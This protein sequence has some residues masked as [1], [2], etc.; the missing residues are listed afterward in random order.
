MLLILI[1]NL[2]SFLSVNRTVSPLTLLT[3]FCSGL[4][5]CPCCQDSVSINPFHKSASTFSSQRFVFSLKGIYPPES[6]NVWCFIV[7]R[8][9]PLGFYCHA[10][11]GK[12]HGICSLFIL[13]RLCASFPS[14]NPRQTKDQNSYC[15]CILNVLS[16]YCTQSSLTKVVFGVYV[17]V[18]TSIKMLYLQIA[19]RSWKLQ[20]RSWKGFNILLVKMSRNPALELL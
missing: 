2:F 8:F 17:Y 7:F 4:P 16:N 6:G 13:W 20:A 12:S 9:L 19:V 10:P 18:S 11:P 5:L 15:V 1:L 14:N 3:L